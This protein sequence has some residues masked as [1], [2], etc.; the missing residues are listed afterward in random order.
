MGDA[1]GDV[2]N[3]TAEGAL[4][5]DIDVGCADKLGELLDSGDG[6]DGGAESP[7]L[8]AG[9]AFEN[10]VGRSDWLIGWDACEVGMFETEENSEGWLDGWLLGLEE[11]SFCPDGREDNVGLVVGWL[12]LWED[13]WLD[14]W[15]LGC[16]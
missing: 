8:G 10:G 3:G 2:S 11:S 9:G 14:G 12:D 7:G 15:P 13:G 4:S 1:D 16:E 6:E 5:L